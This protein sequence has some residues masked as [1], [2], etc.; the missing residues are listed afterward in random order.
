MQDQK[1]KCMI[2]GST[3]IYVNEDYYMLFDLEKG[4]EIIDGCNGKSDP[5]VLRLPSL[6]DIGIK[7]SCPNKCNFC[8]QGDVVEPD[9]LFED[10]KSIIDQVKHHTNQVAL[11]GRG[12]PETHKD[13]EKIVKYCRQSNV[14]PNYTT[15]GQR[16][17][18]KDMDI[19]KEY[20]GACAVSYYPYMKTPYYT[21]AKQMI[22]KGIKTNYHVMFSKDSEQTIFNLLEGKQEI[23]DIIIP[24]GLNAVIFLLFKPWGRATGHYEL[25]PSKESIEKFTRLLS[26]YSSK[27]NG[28]KIGVDSCCACR[29]KEFESFKNFDE[30]TIDICEGARMSAYISPTMKM[31]PCSFG[32][33][34]TNG[35]S[36]KDHTI[37]EVWD[38][39]NYFKEFRKRLQE[40][41]RCPIF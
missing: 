11:G 5:F 31:I 32:D 28:P 35:I 14:V 4:L 19:T 39:A 8:Y 40:N 15:S 3:K 22:K 30:R 9:M 20:C 23:N 34:D 24:D 33:I 38:N 7:G 2:I 27:N 12:D 29:M 26:V 36:L 37:Q 6:F 25:I 17:T 13:F 18:D 41:A 21:T 10:F 1:E 16:T